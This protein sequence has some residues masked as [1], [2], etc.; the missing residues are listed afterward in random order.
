M[1]RRSARE[2]GGAV[3]NVAISRYAYATLLPNETGEFILESADYDEH[4]QAR[5]IRQL[6]KTAR[7]ICSKPRC[8]A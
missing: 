6:G 4:I 8:G 5:D 1:C 7:S 2:A 3:V